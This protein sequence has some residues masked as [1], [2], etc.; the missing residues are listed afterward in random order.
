MRISLR[1]KFISTLSRASPSA[2]AA[3]L[4]SFAEKRYRFV[5]DAPRDLSAGELQVA[6]V[7]GP[8]FGSSLQRLYFSSQRGIDGLDIL[9]LSGVT[10]E[11]SGP[12]FV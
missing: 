11:V 6:E 7:T 4:F 9:G 1:L 2:S 10:Y 3:R 5:Y 12:F 8:A